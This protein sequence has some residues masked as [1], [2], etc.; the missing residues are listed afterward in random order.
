M[1]S[2]VHSTVAVVLMLTPTQQ[3]LPLRVRHCTVLLSQQ[4]APPLTYVFN[5]FNAGPNPLSQGHIF[6]YGPD[7]LLSE[8][9]WSSVGWQG[10]P[11]C[12]ICIQQAGFFGVNGSQVLYTWLDGAE[13]VRV[14][15]IS[16]GN[17]QTLSEAI[18]PTS[19]GWSVAGA[20]NA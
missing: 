1:L 16:T 19:G 10:G 4:W 11:D 9:Y 14:G 12:A 15:F 7:Y 3:S 2:Q 5:T 17:P 20:P 13:N 8:Y 6:Y 18:M